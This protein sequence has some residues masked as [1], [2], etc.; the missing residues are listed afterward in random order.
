MAQ[1]NTQIGLIQYLVGSS[2]Y[3]LVTAVTLILFTLPAF[4]LSYS[5]DGLYASFAL[6]TILVYAIVVSQH[7]LTSGPS[8][9]FNDL[10]S[11]KKFLVSLF[12]IT[13]YNLIVLVSVVVSAIAVTNGGTAIALSVAAIYPI[14]DAITME[15]TIPLSVGGGIAFGVFVLA[16]AGAFGSRAVEVLEDV[17]NAPLRQ[18]DIFKRNGKQYGLLN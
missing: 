13:V 7:S 17:E 9:E 18:F 10:S 15:H 14:W 6:A 4:A 8:K 3:Y 16:K 5:W 1:E 2:I 12:S 11:S